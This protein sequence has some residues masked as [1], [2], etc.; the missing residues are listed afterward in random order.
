MLV[1]PLFMAALIAFIVGCIVA[2]VLMAS[3]FG[4]TLILKLEN[5]MPVAVSIADNTNRYELKTAPPD[6]YVVVKRMTYGEYLKRSGMGTKLKV[7]GS[8]T[9]SRDNFGGEVDID[10]EAIALWDFANCVVE[11]NLTDSNG[12]LLDF[13]KAYDVRRLDPRIGAEVGEYI[14]EMNNFESDESIKN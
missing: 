2:L 4:L 3:L 13:K 11:H 8:T 12:A 5:E 1:S 10:T 6:G 7:S 14:D 9:G